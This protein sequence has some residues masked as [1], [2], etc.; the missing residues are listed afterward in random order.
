MKKKQK[1]LAYCE[2]YIVPVP[3][4]KVNDE[5]EAKTKGS[6]ILMLHSFLPELNGLT[7]LVLKL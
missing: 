1:Q 7:Y 4:K 6:I 5:K 3:E 2:G